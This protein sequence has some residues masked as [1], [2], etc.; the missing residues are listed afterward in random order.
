MMCTS[1]PLRA[2]HEPQGQQC[3]YGAEF[4]AARALD[5]AA[6]CRGNAGREMISL[7]IGVL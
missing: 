6:E 3:A 4:F 7:P 2:A 1:P 5:G